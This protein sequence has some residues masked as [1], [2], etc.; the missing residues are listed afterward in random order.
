LGKREN[1][2]ADGVFHDGVR[3]EVVARFYLVQ[4]LQPQ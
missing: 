1:Q 3:L 4:L 2:C